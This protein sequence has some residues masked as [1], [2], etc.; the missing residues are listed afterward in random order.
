MS[1]TFELSS[2]FHLDFL[3]K[4]ERR[5]PSCGDSTRT[6]SVLRFVLNILFYDKNLSNIYLLLFHQ[7]GPSESMSIMYG[8]LLRKY[9]T[10][11]D[12][13]SLLSTR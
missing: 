10:V 7:G 8:T 1:E 11:K 3:M 4:I 2:L 6:C 12:D 5:C 9:E 13:F